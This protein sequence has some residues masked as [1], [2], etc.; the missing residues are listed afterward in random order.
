MK[1]LKTIF[2]T[3]LG[4]LPSPLSLPSRKN[5]AGGN[6]KSLPDDFRGTFLFL[7]IQIAGKQIIYATPQPLSL[8][9][10]SQ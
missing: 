8:L 10:I 4:I 5:W 6:K 1:M 3:A 7:F 9:I 2:E